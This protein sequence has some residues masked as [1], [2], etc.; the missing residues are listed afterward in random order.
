MT[1]FNR[2]SLFILLVVAISSCNVNNGFIQKRKYQKGYHLSMKKKINN[3]NNI[4]LKYNQ[5]EKK[6]EPVKEVSFNNTSEK[7]NGVIIETTNITAADELANS[8]E[9]TI[10]NVAEKA[11]ENNGNKEKVNHIKINTK[12]L[13][14][15]M[16]YIID[17]QLIKKNNTASKSKVNSDSDLITLILIILLVILALRLFF[18]LDN[19]LGGLLSLIVLILIIVLLLQHFGVI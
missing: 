6:N 17:N 14:E 12:N 9:V 19:L 2:F 5:L 1:L 18:I 15:Q 10:E 4:K 3:S 7:S 13:V 16:K 8:N 11:I